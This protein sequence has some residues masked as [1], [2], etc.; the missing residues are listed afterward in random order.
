MIIRKERDFF[1]TKNFGM[2][3]KIKDS[4]LMSKEPSILKITINGRGKKYL[5]KYWLNYKGFGESSSGKLSNIPPSWKRY[6]GITI[7]MVCWIQYNQVSKGSFNKRETSIKFIQHLDLSYTQL[8][9]ILS[10]AH[11]YL[12]LIKWLIWLDQ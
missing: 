3:G 8:K 2:T 10:L 12:H 7:I 11:I 9:L 5:K 6:N 4:L 1:L